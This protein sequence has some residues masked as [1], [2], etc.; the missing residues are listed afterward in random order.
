MTTI[1]YLQSPTSFIFFSTKICMII[2]RQ[3]QQQMYNIDIFRSVQEESDYE[4]IEMADISF[5]DN[6]TVLNLIEGRIGLI[7]LL[8]EECIRPNGND[9]SFVLKSKAMNKEVTCFVLNPLNLPT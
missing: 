7:S 4:G 5:T 6:T 3:T 1:S 9:S 2:L 8:N